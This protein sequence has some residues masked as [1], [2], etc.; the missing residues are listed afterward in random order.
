[1][2]II[3]NLLAIILR[4]IATM[5][6]KLMQG[7]AGIIFNSVSIFLS[8]NVTGNDSLIEQVLSPIKNFAVDYLI[9]LSM[10][11]LFL[12][13]AWNLVKTIFGSFSSNNDEP[14]VLVGRAIVSGILILNCGLFINL[15]SHD[16][17]MPIAQAMAQIPVEETNK[18]VEGFKAGADMSFGD[19][20]K[21]FGDVEGADSYDSGVLDVSELDP[22]NDNSVTENKKTGSGNNSSK[23]I[24]NSTKWG[25]E[26]TEITGGALGTAIINYASGGDLLVVVILVIVVY[27]IVWCF[28]VLYMAWLM[29]LCFWKLIQRMVAFFICLYMTPLAAACFPSKSTKRIF[30][31]WI[32][33]IAGYGV[34]IILT[35]A[36]LRLSQEVVYN[37]FIYAGS[38]NIL[39]AAMVF[40][41]A[42][43]FLKIIL[44]LEIYVDKLALNAIGTSDSSMLA[45]MFTRDLI[46]RVI[47]GGSMARGKSTGAGAKSKALL[48]SI[49]DIA[50][51]NLTNSRKAATN[52]V[53][54]KGPLPGMKTGADSI[55]AATNAKNLTKDKM[56]NIIKDANGIAHKISKDAKPDKNGMIK[57]TD[58]TKLPYNSQR[59][60]DLSEGQKT[61][62]ANG[63]KLPTNVGVKRAGL[64][65]AANP[66]G[67]GK[68]LKAGNMAVDRDKLTGNVF[69]KDGNAYTGHGDAYFETKN[70]EAI[71]FGAVDLNNIQTYDVATGDTKPTDKTSF[72]LSNSPTGMLNT[73]TNEYFDTVAYNDNLPYN[74]RFVDTSRIAS[75]TK[76]DEVEMSDGSVSGVFKQNLEHGGKCARRYKIVPNNEI[77]RDYIE[78][79]MRNNPSDPCTGYTMDGKHFM[80]AG[81]VI[82]GV[83]L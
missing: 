64:N 52:A 47:G 73:D 70:G 68:Y 76:L 6:A 12:I 77:N 33:M 48:P 11:L 75:F 69:D 31:E 9:P 2:S 16:I 61:I 50:R 7:L 58:G 38:T 19:T 26:I 53:L 15:V 43:S 27:L 67:N 65:L 63:K 51:G 36:F 30:E 29:L 59:Y 56:G 54:G 74:A 72:T 1:M 13:L 62:N 10:E 49:K 71:N 21:L 44:K 4:W 80:V 35:V 5:F 57:A 37:A 45:S 60:K 20:V 55:K 23:K 79:I 14:F 34:T 83:F 3:T 41:I 8:S 66:E 28:M 46:Q 40:G 18:A 17:V 22:T 78:S 42:I 24:D 82:E 81:E 32:R 39:A 25:V